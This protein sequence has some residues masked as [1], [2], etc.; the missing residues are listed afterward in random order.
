ME[1]PGRAMAAPA[2]AGGS[3]MASD[4]RFESAGSGAARAHGK[5]ALASCHIEAH[6]IQKAAS[7][8]K[9]ALDPL[10]YMPD[11]AAFFALFTV[12]VRFEDGEDAA[13]SGAEQ[14]ARRVFRTYKQFSALHS[15]VRK[16]YPK[17]N[18]PRELPSMRK[19]RYDN[20]YIEQ[21]RQVLAC[22]L[23]ATGRCQRALTGVRVLIAPGTQRVPGHTA[24]GPRGALVQAAAR[25]PRG[26]EPVGRQ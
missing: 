20:D 7:P 14:P 9:K 10:R 11:R 16:M 21:K 3:P 2:A 5:R 12:V 4:R 23:P 8:K 24:A 26:Y 22:R 6:T 19:K 13:G 25:V 1:A 15:R 18:L 17:S